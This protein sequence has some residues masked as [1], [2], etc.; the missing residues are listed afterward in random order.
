MAKEI[1]T[2]GH[3]KTL[4]GMK[5]RSL[6]KADRANDAEIYLLRNNLALSI[7][8]LVSINQRRKT[9]EERIQDIE[10]RIAELEA[11]EKEK[12]TQLADNTG[13]IRIKPRGNMKVM[14]VDY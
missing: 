4:M 8:E 11:Q 7:K 6:P 5:H 14:K 10:T 13:E 3:I 9:I 12:R 1:R 2:L